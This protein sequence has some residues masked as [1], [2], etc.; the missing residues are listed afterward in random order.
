MDHTPARHP[1]PALPAGDAAPTL[2]AHGF[3]PAEFEWRPVPRRPRADGWTPDVQQRFI[4]ALGSLGTV[5]RA[6]A[7]VNMSVGS[8]YRLRNA[9]GAESFRRAWRDTLAAAAERLLD[10][11][12]E[13]AIDGW[14]DPVF[15]RDGA[16][17]GSRQRFDHRLA[18][19]IL[20][21]YMPER[22]RHAT[23]DTLRPDETLPPPAPAQAEVLATLAP[24]PPAEPHRLAAP[25]RMAVMIDGARGRAEVEA[26]YPT[27]DAEHYRRPRV[28]DTHSVAS[29]RR[30]ARLARARAAEPPV[31]A[32]AGPY[33]GNPDDP[34]YEDSEATRGDD[35]DR[36]AFASPSDRA[37]RSTRRRKA[38]ADGRQRQRERLAFASP[39]APPDDPTAPTPP[40]SGHEVG[41]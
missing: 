33:R 28:E 5:E 3:D 2:D 37:N 40:D 39:S 13:R 31:E 23:N 26:R 14:Q 10:L 22:F 24:V 6:C 11:C 15:D 9:P 8:A 4:E 30:R 25:D 17:I 19:T 16:R 20:R 21:A 1:V 18:I 35:P 29:E 36:L 32:D 34:W 12:F 41:S 38:R 27:D 7:H